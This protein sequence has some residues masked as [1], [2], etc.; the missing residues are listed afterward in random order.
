MLAPAF[1]IPKCTIGTLGC[2]LVWSLRSSLEEGD[3]YP[4][5]DWPSVF[6]YEAKWRLGGASDS[7]PP[8]VDVVAF[9]FKFDFKYY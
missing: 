4:L 2:E 3:M 6:M 7:I 5:C 8:L 1:V 9:I